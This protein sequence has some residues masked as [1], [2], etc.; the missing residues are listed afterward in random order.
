MQKDSKIY[1][2]VG[3]IVAILIIGIVVY[4]VKANSGPGKLDGFTTSLK[5]DGVVFYG[6]FWCPHCQAMKALFGKSAKLLPYVEC[7]TPDGNSQTQVCIDNKI[8]GY[9]TWLFKN[10]IKIT[11]NSEPTVCPIKTASTT[12]TGVCENAAS[13]Y[14]RVWVFSENS[15]SIRSAT[16]PT[17]NGN[18]WQF[19]SGAETVGEVP[20]SFLAEQIQFTLPQ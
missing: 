6:A 7:S 10:G 12:E 16:D 9:P 17:K 3:L 5:N 19:P 11:A 14:Y 18:V 8:E 4:E 15:F 2:I 13:A 1:L 20:L